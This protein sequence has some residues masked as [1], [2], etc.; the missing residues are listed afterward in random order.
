MVETGNIPMALKKTPNWLMWGRRRILNQDERDQEGKLDKI[1]RQVTGEF[2]KCNNKDTWTTFENVVDSYRTGKFNGIGFAI[3]IGMFCIDIDE[4]MVGDKLPE[5]AVE[6]MTVFQSYAEITPSR[7]VHIWGMGNP[8]KSGKIGKIECYGTDKN[9]HISSRYMTVTGDKIGEISQLNDCDKSLEWFHRNFFSTN[10]D[11]QVELKT[12]TKAPTKARERGKPLAV[13]V[14]TGSDNKIKDLLSDENLRIEGGRN[15]TLFKNVLKARNIFNKYIEKEFLKATT[16]PLAQASVVIKNA[17]VFGLKKSLNL[18]ES[19]TGFID[20]N[21]QKPKI[22]EQ[23]VARELLISEYKNEI[24]NLRYD[25]KTGE[26]YK[27]EGH[28]WGKIDG[29]NAIID[30]IIVNALPKNIGFSSLWLHGVCALLRNTQ[31][32]IFPQPERHLLPFSNGVLNMST[33]TL[34]SH[35]AHNNFRWG[36]PH[37]FGPQN[38]QK[39]VFSNF[40]RELTSTMAE[41]Q[42]LRAYMFAILL[43]MVE[44]EK[45]LV[46]VGLGGTGKGTFIRI[47]SKLV[48]EDN[49]ATTSFERMNSTARFELGSFYLKR[50]VMIPDS[51]FFIKDPTIL[52]TLTGEDYIPYEAKGKNNR[53]DFKMQAML[54]IACNEPLQFGNNDYAVLR[55]MVQV[56]CDKIAVNPD[57]YLEEKID[58]ELPAIINWVLQLGKDN[59]VNILTNAHKIGNN[60]KENLI[61]TSALAQ[62]CHE[63]ISP[64]PEGKCYIGDIK[65]HRITETKGGGGEGPSTQVSYTEVQETTKLYPHFYEFCQFGSMKPLSLQKF[66]RALISFLATMGTVV[67]KERDRAGK[68][69]K[70]IVLTNN[71]SKNA[72]SVVSLKYPGVIPSDDVFYCDDLD[73]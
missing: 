62:W 32:Y 68:Y 16:L 11:S 60:A 47:C 66:S 27:K 3:P 20:L 64:S 43:G 54:L 34:E 46:L 30:K 48:G 59:A 45:Y 31:E 69:I 71:N 49:F 25:I 9:G 40:M 55:R 42:I 2:A 57:L 29:V 70:G 33:Q 36:L 72:P 15:D 4:R 37:E 35:D 17:L 65:V 50:L 28:I 7:G 73:N 5:T 44:L 61:S 6:I 1:P 14:S 63:C 23:G 53:F 51:E 22:V 26:W 67:T 38:T 10:D 41:R 39:P 52:K 58:K 56:K 18:N 8:I 21:G 19:Q 13:E 12:H 24:N